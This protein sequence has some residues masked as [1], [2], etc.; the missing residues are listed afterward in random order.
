MMI[1]H[2]ALHVRNMSLK[3]TRKKYLEILAK[4]YGIE[5]GIPDI[6][7]FDSNA[8]EMPVKLRVHWEKANYA[9][10]VE[11]SEEVMDLLRNEML[12]S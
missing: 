2:Y 11:A 1:S 6:S 4:E 9:A 8:S 3:S 7:R 10:M 12:F 5:G